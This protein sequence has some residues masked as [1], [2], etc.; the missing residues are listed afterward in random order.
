MVRAPLGA[1]R[2]PVVSSVPEAL[3][4]RQASWV[5]LP[6]VPEA[7]VARRQDSVGYLAVPVLAPPVV[8][9]WDPP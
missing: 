6:G 5:G 3:A 4:A 7:S 1:E 2:R 9:A 8:P